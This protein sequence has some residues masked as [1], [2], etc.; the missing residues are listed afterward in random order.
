MSNDSIT[1]AYTM[2]D[3]GKPIYDDG[4]SRETMGG[5]V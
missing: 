1:I 3:D 5:L 2:I 4:R